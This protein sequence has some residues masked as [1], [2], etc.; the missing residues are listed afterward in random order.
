MSH[1]RYQ[2]LAATGATALGLLTVTCATN[3]L[4]W[5]ATL[6]GF[7]SLFLV[8]T[9]ARESRARHTTLAIQRM[10]L[11]ADHTP[12]VLTPCCAFWTAS[13]GQAHSRSCPTR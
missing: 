4:W 1:R 10:A 12:P 2:T 3:G 8:E 9:A 11:E 6:L 5:E 7:G 13:E